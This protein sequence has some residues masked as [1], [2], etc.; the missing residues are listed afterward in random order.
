MKQNPAEQALRTR[1]STGGL[2][3]TG[4]L[5]SD[6]RP[7]AEIQATDAALL[8]DAGLS[9]Q[10]VGDFLETLHQT[11]D[12]GWE[13]RV[14]VLGGALSVQCTETLGQ[15][16]CPFG[17]NHLSHKGSVTVFDS[18]GKLQLTFSPLDAHLIRSHGFFQGLESP[19]RINPAEIIRLYKHCHSS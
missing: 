8:A 3:R 12:E 19:N 5:G 9:Q 4:F 6:S 16:P 10:E 11:A 14:P 17:C 13:C 15:I 1:L 7:I 2:S 18:A